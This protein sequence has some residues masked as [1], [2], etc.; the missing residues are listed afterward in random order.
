MRGMLLTPSPEKAGQ[1]VFGLGLQ[2][3][4]V[5]GLSCLGLGARRAGVAAPCSYVV[6]SLHA[7]PQLTN[8]LKTLPLILRAVRDLG[9]HSVNLFLLLLILF[10]IIIVILIA[11]TIVLSIITITIIIAIIVFYHYYGSYRNKYSYCVSMQAI[12]LHRTREH[13][14][15]TA[16]HKR[17]VG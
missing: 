10:L 7:K 3:W 1:C 5:L 12:P 13:F 4:C 15:N 8:N 6:A 14:S 2:L 16:T 17:S 9:A 11:I